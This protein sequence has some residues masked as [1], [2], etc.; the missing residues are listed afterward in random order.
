MMLRLIAA[1][2]LLAG[3][4]AAQPRE[5]TVVGFGG[6]FQEAARRALFQPFAAAS[7]IAVRDDTYNGEMARI[8]AMVRNRD[9]VWDLVM[10]EAPELA[11]GCEDGVF[12]K[13]DWAA[14]GRERFIAAGQHECGVGA[15]AWGAAVFWDSARTPAGPA[16]FAELFDVQKFPGKRALRTGPKMTLEIALMADGVAQADVYRVLATRAG[17]DRAF[18]ALERIRPHLVF[19]RAGAQPFQLVASGEV[20]FAT[21]FT[22]R[23]VSANAQGARLAMNWDTML[24]SVD[25]WAMPANGPRATDAARMI[26][27]MTQLDPLLALAAIWPASPAHRAFSERADLVAANPNS[28]ASNASRGLFI[29]TQF[30]IEHGEDLEKRFAAW[31]AR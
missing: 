31:A 6:G 16:S 13:V 2:L 27:W 10:V 30:W 22:G 9:V 21:G 23:V 18:A 7:G 17:Q 26:N 5:L 28:V 12:A 14:M 19:W 3:T 11:R 4:A 29:D 20:A 1:T 24:Y 25:Y 8:Y 15:V